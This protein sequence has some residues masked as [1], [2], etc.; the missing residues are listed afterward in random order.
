M[1]FFFNQILNLL[2]DNTY[3]IYFLGIAIEGPTFN[4]A[5][6]FLA[7][8]GYFNIWVIFILAIVGQGIGDIFPFFMGFFFNKFFSKRFKIKKNYKLIKYLENKTKKDTL[9]TIII[10]KLTPYI[11]AT[12]YFILGV[13]RI[14]I[15][16]FVSTILGLSLFFS[17]FYTLIGYFYGR[18]YTVLNGFLGV[19]FLIIGILIFIMFPFFISKILK[20]FFE[21]KK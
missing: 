9:R 14:D 3:F 15:K 7:S 13:M 10:I 18:I 4:V 1:N 6:A 19:I 12:A 8:Q 5:G 17:I 21:R 16:K 20:S 11:P 2:K